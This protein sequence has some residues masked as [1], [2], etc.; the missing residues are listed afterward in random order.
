MALFNQNK[1]VAAAK[2]VA[3]SATSKYETARRNL[4]LVVVFTVVNIVLLLLN[5][6]T[7]FL[8]SAY[9]PYTI[10]VFARFLCGMLPDEY[11]VGYDVEFFPE[12]VFY[13]VLAIAAVIVVFY[14]L[15]FIFS[16]KNRY[17]WL[18]TALVLFALDTVVMVLNLDFSAFDYHTIIDIVFH[19]WIIYILVS[20]VITGINIAKAPV[21]EVAAE[22]VPVANEAAEASPEIKLNGDNADISDK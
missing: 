18:I 15:C 14:L 20:G 12:S 19:A 4:L 2:T 9:V 5:A 8:F 21:T 13:V 1:P 22:F 7:Y 3:T 16:G 17:G 10:A 6:N 11:Y